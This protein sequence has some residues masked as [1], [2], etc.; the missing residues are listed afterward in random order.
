MQTLFGL[1]TANWRTTTAGVC[2]AILA[3]VDGVMKLIDTDPA[4]NPDYAMIM[5]TV[6]AAVGLIRARDDVVTSREME[7]AGVLP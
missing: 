4:T 7:K 6:V 3:I 2:A 5:A 1:R